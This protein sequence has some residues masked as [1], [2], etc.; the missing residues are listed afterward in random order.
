ML[1]GRYG[2]GGRELMSGAMILNGCYGIV[3]FSSAVLQL[4]MMMELL[5]VF[6]TN[7]IFGFTGIKRKEAPD[8]TLQKDEAMAPSPEDSQ[9]AIYVGGSVESA[10]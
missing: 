2:D 8:L 9:P 10:I 7:Q 6:Q 3:G 5:V 1:L 4:L